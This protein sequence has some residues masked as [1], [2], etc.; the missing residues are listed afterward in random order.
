METLGFIIVIVLGILGI[1]IM[2]KA[3]ND[4][5]DFDDRE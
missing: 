4:T 5:E 1:W 3:L 2:L